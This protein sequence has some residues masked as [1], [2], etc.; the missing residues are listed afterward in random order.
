MDTFFHTF[1]IYLYNTVF[2]VW[3]T[4]CMRIIFNIRLFTGKTNS[5]IEFMFTINLVVFI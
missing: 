5:V 3:E 4:V 2:T 1:Y